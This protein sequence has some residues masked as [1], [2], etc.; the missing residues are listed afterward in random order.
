[1]EDR[2]EHHSF[3]QRIAVLIRAIEANDDARIE[4]AI[5]RLSQQRR[6][7]APLG[8]AIGALVM[9]FNGVKL[10]VSNWRLTLVQILPAMW[11]WLAMLDLKFHVLHGKSFNVVRG[12]VLIP[13]CLAVVLLTVA[14]FA[15]NAVF[16]LAIAQGQ[17]PEIRPAVAEAGKH[18]PAIIASGALVGA[19]LAFSTLIVTRWRGP[20]FAL[21]LGITVGVMMVSYVAVPARIIGVKTRQ[22]RRDKL[23]AGAIGGLLSATVC[24]P[25]YLLGRLAI[26]MLGSKALLVPAIILLVISATLQSG[27]TGSVRAIKMSVKLAPHARTGQP[28]PETPQPAG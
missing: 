1:M 20:W 2:A 21:S 27:A 3:R 14:S 24:T 5:L 15:L 9:L 12:P 6:I 22:S 25:P 19:M 13:L 10:L 11:I 18:S 16:A 17:R 7:F 23:W 26:L 4:E 8:L 28:P